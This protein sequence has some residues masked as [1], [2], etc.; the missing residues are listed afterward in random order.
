VPK[1]ED[2]IARDWRDEE[3]KSGKQSSDD[4]SP[5]TAATRGYTSV[6]TSAVT[7]KTSNVGHREQRACK[8][9]S[10]KLRSCKT[11]CD[12]QCEDSAEKT[13]NRCHTCGISGFFIQRPLYARWFFVSGR[14]SFAISLRQSSVFQ[15]GALRP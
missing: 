6:T 9:P 11:V 7:K 3:K 5:T 13:A 2:L 8:P 4:A 15:P 14:K 10:A 1:S 12:F